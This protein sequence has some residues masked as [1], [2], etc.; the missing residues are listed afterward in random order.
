MCA[1]LPCICTCNAYYGQKQLQTC[2]PYPCSHPKSP[3]P[4]DKDLLLCTGSVS[5]VSVQDGFVKNNRGIN[6]G[7]DLPEEF[8]TSLYDRIATNEIKTKDSDGMGKCVCVCVC[9]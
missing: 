7:Q 4:Y 5:Y 9:V 3:V 1:R 8:L 2:L 6:D